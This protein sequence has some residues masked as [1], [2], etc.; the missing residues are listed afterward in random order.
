MSMFWKLGSNEQ[1][2]PLLGAERKRGSQRRQTP[3]AGGGL[4]AGHREAAHALSG[5]FASNCLVTITNTHCPPNAISSLQRCVCT[6]RHHPSG[7]TERV[8]EGFI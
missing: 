8:L 3:Q 1:G 6:L 4:G 2:W 5:R 7:L